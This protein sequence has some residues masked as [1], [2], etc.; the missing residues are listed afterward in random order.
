MNG[1]KET[2]FNLVGAVGDASE[3][4]SGRCNVNVIV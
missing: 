2:N 3:T 1:V 4:R